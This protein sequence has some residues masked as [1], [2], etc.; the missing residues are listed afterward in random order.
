M[1]GRR[2]IL[3]GALG[4]TALTAGAGFAWWR[5]SAPASGSGA[6]PAAFWQLRFERPQG[7][8]LVLAEFRSRPLLINFWATWCPPC[9]RELP[10]IDRFARDHA[11]RGLGA[12]GLAI[13][14]KAPVANFLK[15]SALQLPIG[16]CGTDGV[17]IAMQ[18]GNDRGGLPYTVLLGADG[19]LRERRLGETSYAEMARWVQ[20]LPG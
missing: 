12:I 19:A 10:E 11:R 8:E 2:Q 15:D 7:G 18:L 16:L 3:V 4:A 17:E 9:V 13:D 6:V 1:T 20:A 5:G 14:S